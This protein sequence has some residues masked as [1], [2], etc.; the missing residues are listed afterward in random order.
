MVIVLGR[1]AARVKSTGRTAESQ[2]AHAFTFR[3]G[4]VASWY[5]YYDTAKY[6]QAYEPAAAGVSR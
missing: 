5:E 4:K 2:W 6:A 3:D 1:Y